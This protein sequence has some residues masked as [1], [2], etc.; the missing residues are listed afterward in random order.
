MSFVKL[1]CGTLDSTLW[2]DA[3]A[4][5]VF[6]AALLMAEPRELTEPMKQIKV[7]TLEETGFIVPVGWYG[8]V[9]AAGVG[10]VRRALMDEETGIAALERLGN[11]ELE[12]RTPD[13]D[14]RRLVRVSGGFIALNFARYRE[15]DH[16]GA[17]RSKRYRENK[18]KKKF[19]NGFKRMTGDLS[20]YKASERRFVKALENG[21]TGTADAIAAESSDRIANGEEIQ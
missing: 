3:D 7:R 14:G 12:S 20:G 8:F 15:K 6:F 13:Y 2:A 5:R 10:I 9:S 16:T 21:D 19:R 11:P 17:E 18:L 1:D 4:T